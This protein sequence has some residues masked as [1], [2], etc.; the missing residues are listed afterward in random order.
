MNFTESMLGL[1]RARA[2]DRDMARARTSLEL[3]LGD[4]KARISCILNEILQ[5]CLGAQ[6]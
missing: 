2:R 3:G 4:W 1:A 5:R 6:G